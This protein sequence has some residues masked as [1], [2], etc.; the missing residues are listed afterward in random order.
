MGGD[1]MQSYIDDL[2]ISIFNFVV[3]EGYADRYP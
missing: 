2:D 3:Y 1:T